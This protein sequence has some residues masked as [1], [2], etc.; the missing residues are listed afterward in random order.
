MLI[1]KN[2]SHSF[3]YLL[4]ENVNLQINPKDKIAI[5]GSSGS[6]KSTLLHILSALLKPQNGIVEYEGKDIYSISEKELIE[7]RKKEFGI[8]FQ[9]HYLFNTFTALENL[10]AAA[11]L[12]QREV[13]MKLLERLKI[14]DVINQN[15]QTL[16]GGQQQRVSIAR[17]LTKHP[18][19]I[20]ADEPTGNLDKENANEVIDVLFEYCDENNAAL[21]TVTH[22]YEIAKRFE[23]V[24][25]LKDK[26][27]N[28]WK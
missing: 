26:R 10:Q 28:I 18:K 25:E 5:I 2:L 8:I 4:F 15:I 20:F 6:G 24:Y 16:S 23:R 12:A 17:V 21:L 1:A 14:K 11:I 3:D 7:I 13:D 27:L 22:D 9:F 19:I